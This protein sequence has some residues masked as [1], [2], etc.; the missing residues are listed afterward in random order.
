[1]GDPMDGPIQSANSSQEGIKPKEDAAGTVRV[2]F[3]AKEC[4][5]AS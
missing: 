4:N 1:M 2:D 3:T 5:R